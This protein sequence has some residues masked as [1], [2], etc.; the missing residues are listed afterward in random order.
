MINKKPEKNFFMNK[1]L[2]SWME[3]KKNF[4]NSSVKFY[5]VKCKRQVY[6]QIVGERELDPLLQVDVE[7]DGL[8]L[9]LY[10]QDPHP[11]VASRQLDP[12]SNLHFP[13]LQAALWIRIRCDP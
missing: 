9:V 1:A 12:S 10:C 2:I 8:R 4:G 7:A 6:L 5:G 3:V 13:S 11:T